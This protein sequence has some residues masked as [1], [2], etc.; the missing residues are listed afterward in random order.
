[1][2]ALW[3]KLDAKAKWRGALLASAAVVMASWVYWGAWRSEPEYQGRPLS[4]WVSEL[5]LTVVLHDSEGDVTFKDSTALGICGVRFG[6]EIYPISSPLP[7]EAIAEIGRNAVP[8]LLAELQATDSRFAR[9]ME[10]VG[11]KFSLEPPKALLPDAAVRHAQALTAF[12]ILG[13][14]GAAALPE[15]RRMTNSEQ[16]SV[17]YAARLIL[18]G[19][20]DEERGRWFWD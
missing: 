18:E 19:L 1:M 9:L 3:R 11:D 13:T 20:D 17:R 5:P 2:I 7:E 8:F 14:N 4:F 15:L 10:R 6:P 12:R 16:A